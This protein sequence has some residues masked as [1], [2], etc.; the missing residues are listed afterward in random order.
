[1]LRPRGIVRRHVR[2]RIVYHGNGFHDKDSLT[3]GEVCLDHSRV[4]WSRQLSAVVLPRWAD[5]KTATA[6]GCGA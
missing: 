3:D 5:G 2:H 4:P 1:M 6:R